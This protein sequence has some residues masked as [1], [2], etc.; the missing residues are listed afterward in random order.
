MPL[1]TFIFGKP[2]FNLFPVRVAGLTSTMK[3]LLE[4]LPQYIKKETC[5]NC[6]RGWEEETHHPLC[7]IVWKALFNT[8]MLHINAG[9]EQLKKKNPTRN[10]LRSRFNKSL[11]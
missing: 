1:K 11:G 6:Q 8:N 5:R 2:Y 3:K 4:L 7:A 10:C 9:G